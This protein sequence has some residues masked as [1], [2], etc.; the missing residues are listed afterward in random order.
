MFSDFLSF[1][2]Y[3]PKISLIKLYFSDNISN[4]F[5]KLT[6]MSINSS[7]IDLSQE[8]SIDESTSVASKPAVK[9]P[10]SHF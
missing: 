4:L 5:K 7:S 1:I 8:D 3:N 2:F 6:F 9:K 10:I